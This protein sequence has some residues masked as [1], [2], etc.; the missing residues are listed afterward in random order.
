MAPRTP[1]MFDND[2]SVRERHKHL[3]TLTTPRTTEVYENFDAQGVIHVSENDTNVRKFR[4][5]RDRPKCTR[6]STALRTTQVF[7]NDINVRD[8]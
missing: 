8:V 7:E 3:R 6:T 2:P 4:Q 1:Q 5:H